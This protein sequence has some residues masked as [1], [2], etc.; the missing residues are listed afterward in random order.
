MDAT[1]QLPDETSPTAEQPGE[2]GRL[3]SFSDRVLTLF[4]TSILGT[5]IGILVGFLLARVLG[6]AGKGDFYLITLFPVTIMVLIQLGLPQAF[7][8]FAAR[9]QTTGINTKTVI[10][11]VALAGP[12]LA[13]AIAI[14]PLLRV[15]I[16]D[17]IDPGEIIL[18]LLVLP[19]ALNATFATGV[20]LGRQS[21]RWYSAVNLGQSVLSIVI[22]IVLV[23]VLGLGLIGALSAFFVCYVFGTLGYFVGSVRVSAKVPGRTP[24]SYRQLFGYGLPYYPGTLTSFL[25][26]RVDVYLL[27]WI[28]ADPAAPL[29]YYSMAVTIAQLVFFLPNAVSSVFFPHVAGTNREDADRQVALVARVTLLLTGAMA[30]AL[31]PVSIVGI[32]VLLPAFDQSLVPLFVILPGVVALSQTKVLSSY[33]AGLG[34]TAVTSYANVGSLVVNVA[35]NLL[36]IPKFGIVGAAAASLV[37]YSVSAIALSVVAARASHIPLAD[38]WIP[39]PSDLRFAFATSLGMARRVLR[40][41]AGTT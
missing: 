22:Y 12:A 21:V 19:L 8:F 28:L 6:P 11:T 27:A 9:G 34:M 37:S 40:R 26:L 30:V 4:A 16:L 13:L 38:F 15:T 14:L 3:E 17:S 23:G 41:A 1:G 18:G 29:G 5:G 36:L 10:L 33:L 39:R 31:V 2:S 35:V 32:R 7:G 20:L 24:V 25:S